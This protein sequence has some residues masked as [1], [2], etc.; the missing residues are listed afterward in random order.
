MLSR[1][2]A[3]VDAQTGWLSALDKRLTAPVR[4]SLGRALLPAIVAIFALEAFTGLA[5]A[6]HY[7]PTAT[8]AWASVH[9][10]EQRVALGAL[11]RGAHA[12]GT[13][14]LI[15]LLGLAVVHG[16]ATAAWRRRGLGWLGLIGLLGVLP[17][18]PMTGNLLPWDETGYWQTE[19]E[20]A[21][22]GNVPALG[23]TA[24]A[25]AL[26]GAEIGSATLTRY[27][28]A[29]TLL[30]PALFLVPL[31]LA[32][33]GL[34]RAR[35]E[36]PEEGAPPYFPR[37]YL[38]ELG[39]AAAGVAAVFVAGWLLPAPLGA[40]GDPTSPIDARPEWY[41]MPLYALRKALE[42]PLEIV[43]TAVIPGALITLLAA[44]PVL[45]PDGKRRWGFAALLGAGVAALGALS[46]IAMAQ[47]SDNA[48]YQRDRERVALRAAIAKEYAA[49]TPPGIDGNVPLFEGYRL[50]VR[51]GCGECHSSRV[52][53]TEVPKAPDLRGF[54]S[55]PWL[56]RFLVNPSHPAHFGPTKLDHSEEAG[57][58][59][60]PYDQLPAPVRAGLVEF[61]VSLRGAAHDAPLAASG[62]VTFEAECSGCHDLAG[63][64]GGGPHL[65]GYGS[66]AWISSVILDPDHETL[67]GELG[68]DMPD[69]PHLDARQRAAIASWL[70]HEGAKGKL[71]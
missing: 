22:I 50:F 57:T 55:R 8:D 33:V 41:F 62:K 63:N 42:G 17:L 70:L 9:R 68:R 24:R 1:I 35:P 25:V 38:L 39:V 54:L 71:E 13:V 21:I 2:G 16:V 36:S 19:V 37:Q 61:L 66:V 69:F 27:Y 20:A 48:S 32:W 49:E 7:A 65:R 51:E 31:T 47:D 3:A 52:S 18:F 40:P 29:H 14:A 23:D 44:L 5:L 67:Y 11:L 58:G 28:A 6:F 56:D 10:I 4:P 45:D 59:M 53:Q 64:A 30:L 46:G 26:G 34:R 12:A 60:P 15:V 43:G